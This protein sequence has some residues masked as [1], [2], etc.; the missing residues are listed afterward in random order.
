MCFLSQT[1]S[2]A[3]TAGPVSG[4]QCPLAEGS[5]GDQM[6]ALH[7]CTDVFARSKDP[8][9]SCSDERCSRLL[10]IQGSQINVPRCFGFDLSVVVIQPF[11]MKCVPKELHIKSTRQCVKD[12]PLKT[13]LKCALLSPNR[14]DWE[15]KA[16][17]PGLH[18]CCICKTTGNTSSL[19][20]L[21]AL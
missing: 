3:Q 18:A 6:C 20:L 12:L 4:Q 21:P 7:L 17:Q 10:L 15:L 1:F 8:S 13:T 14:G 19:G 2:C 11:Q 5:S 16:I 9:R